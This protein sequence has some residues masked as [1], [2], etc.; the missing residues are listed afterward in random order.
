MCLHRDR[1]ACLPTLAATPACNRRHGVAATRIVN[2]DPSH[3][4]PLLHCSPR[5]R[6]NF[7][8]SKRANRSRRCSA[9]WFNRALERRSPCGSVLDGVAASGSAPPNR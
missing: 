9:A 5:R 8:N 3:S 7:S 6:A 4:V 1:C 2:T